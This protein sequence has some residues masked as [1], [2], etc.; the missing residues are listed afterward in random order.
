[1]TGAPDD[2]EPWY[3]TQGATWSAGVLGLVVIAAIVIAVIN[4]SNDAKRAP[5]GIPT[6]VTTTAT[7]A[8]TTRTL[9]TPTTSGTTTSTLPSAST[10]DIGGPSVETSPGAS[11]PSTSTSERDTE[12]DE[13]TQ[14]RRRGPTT[15]TGIVVTP[16]RRP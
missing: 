16:P 1:M 14:T 7:A 9:V 10:T 5:V 2:E 6:A 12:T 15:R 4:T 3:R 11:T 13:P 8:T